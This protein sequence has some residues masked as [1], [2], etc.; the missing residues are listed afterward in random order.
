MTFWKKRSYDD[1]NKRKVT[2]IGKG[3]LNVQQ[4]EI[5]LWP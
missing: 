4:M 1:D 2:V 5:V 3:W